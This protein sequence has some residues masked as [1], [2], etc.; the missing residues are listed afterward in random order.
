VA[1]VL[2]YDTYQLINYT[3]IL[4]NL[5]AHLIQINLFFESILFFKV[6]F[7]AYNPPR[8]VI[9]IINSF[10]PLYLFDF[11]L[12]SLIREYHTRIAT[13]GL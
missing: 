8:R 1:H 4:L 12:Q 2:T 10:R 13:Q 3:F 6:L 7:Y 9:T 11:A 5:S